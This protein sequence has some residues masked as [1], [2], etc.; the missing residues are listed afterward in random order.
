MVYSFCYGGLTALDCLTD[1]RTPVW[2]WFD[3]LRLSIVTAQ[4]PWFGLTSSSPYKRSQNVRAFLPNDHSWRW[5]SSSTS[6]LSRRYSLLDTSNR[7]LAPWREVA[8]LPRY[9]ETY[10]GEIMVIVVREVY[11]CC[12]VY[13]IHTSSEQK[14]P[15]GTRLSRQVC[16]L[17]I[18]LFFFIF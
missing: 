9:I 6:N 3:I 2:S 16:F 7:N 5:L 15:S 11:V 14:V 18:Y 4:L 8:S 1:P 10:S 17:K 13:G 12:V